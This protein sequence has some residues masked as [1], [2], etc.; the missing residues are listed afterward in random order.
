[1]TKTSKRIWAR[2][3]NLKKSP[4]N[5][6]FVQNDAQYRTNI[7][8]NIP[9]ITDGTE[10]HHIK[11]WNKFSEEVWCKIVQ[12]GGVEIRLN[13]QTRSILDIRKKVQRRV[14]IGWNIL[15]LIVLFRNHKKEELP[16]IPHITVKAPPQVSW[17]KPYLNKFLLKRR[18]VVFPRKDLTRA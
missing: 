14:V 12:Q 7:H 16:S 3:Q 11:S 13:L 1:M 18:P 2:S 8:V 10:A 4:N 9:S 5:C 17:K 6:L 15:R